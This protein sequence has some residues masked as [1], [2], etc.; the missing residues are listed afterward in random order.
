VAAACS[1]SEHT[2]PDQVVP[3]SRQLVVPQ[4]LERLNAARRRRDVPPAPCQATVCGAR[5]IERGSV[6]VPRRTLRS[7]PTLRGREVRPNRVQ[8]LRRLLPPGGGQ[9]ADG[10]DLLLWR[11]AHEDERKRI[12]VCG[13]GVCCAVPLAVCRCCARL[14]WHGLQLRSTSTR[15]I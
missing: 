6:A 1:L 13:E 5:P 10:Q 4:P 9:R 11:Q 15:D 8:P 14:D 12:G 3:G 7:K 2:L